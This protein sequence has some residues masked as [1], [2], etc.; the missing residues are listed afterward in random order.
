M[1]AAGDRPHDAVQH[2]DSGNPLQLHLPLATVQC[3]T[4]GFVLQAIPRR[5][6]ALLT[7]PLSWQNALDVT[8]LAGFL[9]QRKVRDVGEE[10]LWFELDGDIGAL[11][12][13]D[14]PPPPWSKAETYWHWRRL[15]GTGL[16]TAAP[17]MSQISESGADESVAQSSLSIMIRAL[18][19]LKW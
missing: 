16:S 3:F 6:V 7:L 17:E 14:A 8:P 13:Y 19:R 1:K 12:C 18:R 4:L 9:N 11:V 5:E 2:I 15:Q 10:R